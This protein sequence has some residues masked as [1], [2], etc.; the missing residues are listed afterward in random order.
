MFH[1]KELDQL[2][3]ENIKTFQDHNFDSSDFELTMDERTNK[4]QEKVMAI[5]AYN[6]L[7]LELAQLEQIQQV[8]PKMQAIQLETYKASL[9][10]SRKFD[11]KQKTV[12]QQ[13][14]AFEGLVK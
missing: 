9:M 2:N 11:W 8:N 6:K 10:H 5:R 4:Q 14:K 12:E 7:I 3:L 1:F 13:M